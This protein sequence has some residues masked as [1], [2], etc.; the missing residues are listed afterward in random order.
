M[1]DNPQDPGSIECTNCAFRM[2]DDNELF[3]LGE[4]NNS[5]RKI[6]ENTALNLKEQKIISISPNARVYQ[7]EY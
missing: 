2:L 5:Y 6:S 1:S 7:K 3:W 4:N